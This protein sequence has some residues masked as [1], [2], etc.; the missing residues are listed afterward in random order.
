MFDAQAWIKAHEPP[1]YKDLSGKE[2]TGKL[3]SHPQY[4]K[5]QK[6]FRGWLTRKDEMTDEQY[7]DELKQLLSSMSFNDVVVAEMVALP[8]VAL[9]E[10]VFGFFGLQ[11]AG[12]KEF[13]P[14]PPA[15]STPEPPLPS[16]STPSPTTPP[17]LTPS[18]S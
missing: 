11:R 12:A 14:Q 10:L 16:S 18:A 9:E 5:W 3:W 15:S 6:V 17:A 4:V 2:H 1:K 13:Q 7:A 8:S